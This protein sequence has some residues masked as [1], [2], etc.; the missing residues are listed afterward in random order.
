MNFKATKHQSGEDFGAVR[1][2]KISLF[3]RKHFCLHGIFQLSADGHR[4]NAHC[5]CPLS[6][7]YGPSAAL[8]WAAAQPLELWALWATEAA[9]AGKA[10]AAALGASEAGA[11]CLDRAA[12]REACW[13]EKDNL[14]GGKCVLRIFP[15]ICAY[16]AI[17]RGRPI[18]IIGF[19]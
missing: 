19:G 5:R 14:Q 6:L 3:K 11:G 18:K 16:F 4:I 9:A 15:H 17:F 7:F 8:S 2:Q 1:V 12:L 13:G 10:H